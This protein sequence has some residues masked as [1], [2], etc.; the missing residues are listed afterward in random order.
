MVKS[1]FALALQNKSLQ[2]LRGVEKGDFHNHISRGGTIKNYRDEF[3]IPLCEKPLKFDGYNGMESLYRANIRKHFDDTVYLQRI[4]MALQH[5]VSDGIKIAV[6]TYGSKELSLFDSH[7]EF[8]ERQKE[9]FNE[10]APDMQLIP[11]FGINTNESPEEIERGIN[12]ILKLNFFKSIDIHGLEMTNPCVYKKIY[13]RAYAY[14]LKLRA[15]VGETGE[16]EVIKIAIK[17][18]KLEEINHG[19]KAV[20]DITVIKEI[21]RRKIRV[22][23]CP[24]SNIY[25]GIYNSLKVHP[26]RNLYD[27]GINLTIGTDD[28]LIFNKSITEIFLDLYQQQVFSSQ[29]LDRIR[30]NALKF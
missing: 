7:N 18:L 20:L 17:E 28:M 9:L 1:S 3:G 23:L 25:L 10:Y 30:N 21:L 26:I 27:Y 22:N 12:D 4:K 5:M 29:E 14:G 11:E 8:V 24:Y 6:I 13:S 19:N 16:P 15:H 2:M